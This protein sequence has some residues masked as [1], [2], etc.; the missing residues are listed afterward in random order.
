MGEVDLTNFPVTFNGSIK[1]EARPERLTA[2]AGALI[3]REMDERMGWTEFLSRNLHDPRNQLFITHPM[4]ELLRTRMYLIAQGWNDQDDADHLRD[5]PAFRVAVSNRRGD[6]PLRTRKKHGEDENHPDGLASQPTMSRLIDTLATEHNLHVLHEGLAVAVGFALQAGRGHRFQTSTLD[7]DSFPIE[8]HGHQAGSE[9][10]GYYHRRIFNPI[11]AMVSETEDFVGARLREGNASTAEGLEDFVMPLIEWMEREIC[12]VASVRGDAGMPSEPI[13][14]RL[15]ARRNG[16]CFRLKS[17]P[18]LDTL[19][20]PHLKRP[21]GGRPKEERVFFK[22]LGYKAGPWS[23]ERRVVLVMIDRPGELFLHRF[24][25]LTDWSKEQMSGEE[26]L[27]FYRKRGTHEGHLGEFMNALN[28]ALSC[29][30]RPKKCYGGQAVKKHWPV[31]SPEGDFLANE[32]TLL[33]YVWAYNLA[34]RV[35]HLVERALPQDRGPS[36]TP[37][38]GGWSLSRVQQCVLR[39]MARFVLHSRRVVAVIGQSAAAFWNSLI[40]H[41]ARF[42]KVTMPRS[43]HEC[44]SPDG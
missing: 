19:A 38:P 26:L 13:L 15:E 29:T 34:N 40:P 35:R 39:V 18:V 44:H 27:S 9:Y 11:V 43:L 32:A 7:V 25:L 28:V 14:A 2:D 10:N 41:I 17:N 30:S 16:Y 20:K 36:A 22:E 37:N 31:R 12:V 23:R 21:P 3:L 24:F 6:G 8:V 33:L 5:D 4:V 42:P 1:V